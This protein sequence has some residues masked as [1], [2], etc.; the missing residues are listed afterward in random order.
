MGPL[1]IAVI[2]DLHVG[3]GAR[4]ADLCLHT[5]PKVPRDKD[6]VDTFVRFLEREGITADFLIVPGDV[7]NAAQP[8]EF[9][10]ASINIERIRVALSVSE[11]RLIVVPGNHDVDW[12]IIKHYPDD[13]SGLRFKQRYDPLCQGDCVFHKVFARAQHRS[14]LAAPFCCVWE[15]DNALVAGHNSSLHDG[16]NAEVHHGLVPSETVV[17][18]ER[19]LSRLDRSEEKL[20]IFV[21]HHHPILYSDP[22]GDEPDF[23]AM[24][25]A[26][27]L[28]NLLEQFRFDL[29]IHGHKHKPNFN[30]YIKNST[31]PLAILGAGSFSYLLDTRW[32]GLVNNQFHLVRVKKRDADSG[33]ICGSV[34]SYTYLTGH[35]WKPSAPHNGIE[36]QRS[37][38]RYAIPADLCKHLRPAIERV[39]K[40]HSHVKWQEL[41][42]G[43]QTLEF[44]QRDLIVKALDTLGVEMGFERYSNVPQEIILLRK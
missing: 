21:V 5:D 36:H 15:F 23:S 3:A 44:L 29:I 6:Y 11:G 25:N 20:K 14:L 39:F 41:V 43:D 27:N 16:P 4:A 2:S 30:T 42:D 18:L 35:G 34:E 1:N 32:S 40:S 9:K 33:L 13:R 10:V 12:S 22:V 38:G 31:H 28:L 8:D 17:E 24:T 37:F 7:S 26:E 19:I